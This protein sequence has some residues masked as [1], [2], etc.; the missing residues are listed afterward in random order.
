MENK[1]LIGEVLKPQGITG[2]LKLKDYSSGYDSIKKIKS[3]FIGDEERRVLNLR[4]FGGAVFLTVYGVSDRNAAESLRGKKVYA[5]REEVVK[6]ENEFFIVDVI[7]CELVLSS[8]K[9]LG[10]ITDID[11]AKIDVYSVE[12][13]EGTAVFPMLSRLNPVFDPENRRVT[14]DASTF[15][16]VV[17]YED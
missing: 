12:T 16:E 7:G 1:L 8:G 13:N 11:S 3:V 14:V 15:T 5:K 4:A 9:V 6:P 2:E 17:M 10:K